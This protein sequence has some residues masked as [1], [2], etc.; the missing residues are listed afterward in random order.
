MIVK[1]ATDKAQAVIVAPAKRKA[2]IAGEVKS[3]KKSIEEYLLAM[4]AVL[5]NI[6]N[7]K[8]STDVFFPGEKVKTKIA[9]TK[10]ELNNTSSTKKTSNV[11]VGLCSGCG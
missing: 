11:S 8:C 4:Q 3:A 7:Q 2:Y 9:S 10:S 6:C 1:K 5:T